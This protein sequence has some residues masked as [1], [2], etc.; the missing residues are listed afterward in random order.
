ML[1]I[2]QLS[3]EAIIKASVAIL[4]EYGLSDMT[5]RRVAKQLNV[6][7]G[8]LYWHFKN[9]Q[10][11]I[12]ATSRHL[13]APVLEHSEEQQSSSS[14]QE[15]CAELRALMLHTKDGAEIV[16]AALSN[17]L[18]RKDLE[19]RISTSFDN[20]DEVGAFTLLHFVVGAVLTEQTQLQLQELTGD[21]EELD[22]TTS[23]ERR[24][25]QGVETIMAGLEALSHIR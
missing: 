2:V 1:G 19:S 9:K 22:A 25:S 18:L 12:D 15:T 14:A 11:L 7:P 23:F 17:Q 4:S 16:S 20:P 8:A 10:E 5:M 13:L 3:K 6:A 21:S 24:F